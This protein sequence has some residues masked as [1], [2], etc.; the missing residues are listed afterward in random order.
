MGSR[1]EFITLLGGAAV[2]WPLAAGA[3]QPTRVARIGYV[4]GTGSAA[5]PGPFVEALQQGMREHGY[6][7]GKDFIVEYRGAEGRQARVPE[8]IAE[9]VQAKVDVLVTPTPI[10]VRA[11][12]QATDTIPIVMVTSIDPV[13]NGIIVS[14]AKPGENITGL[15]TL[16][17]DL[18]AKR[19]EFLKDMVPKLARVGILA[20]AGEPVAARGYRE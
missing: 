20:D 1:R 15:F 14:L 10:A 13:A 6:V 19:L 4:S 2:A 12:K 9:L 18:S 7:V 17:R 3:Q 11:A 5:D 8:L 16:T